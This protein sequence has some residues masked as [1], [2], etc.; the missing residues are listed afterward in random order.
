MFKNNDNNENVYNNYIEKLNSLHKLCHWKGNKMS[1]WKLYYKESQKSS[2]FVGLKN[3]GCTCYINSLIQIFY[4]TPLIRESL[5]KCDYS[6]FNEKNC[7]YQLIK[8][9]YSLKYLQTSFYVPTS[10]V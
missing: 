9:F 5:L 8:I 6:S 4:H 2:P 10:F 3:L 1:D 7:F